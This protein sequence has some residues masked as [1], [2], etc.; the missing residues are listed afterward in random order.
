MARVRIAIPEPTSHDPEY[1]Q[2]S[3]PQYVA[4]IE[5]A[6]GEA[7]PIALDTPLDAI[8]KMA[9]GCDGILL[10]GS[11]AD[12]D[13]LRYRQDRVL[14]CA[15]KDGA[16][17]AADDLL[18]REAIAA[19]KPLLGICFGLQSL[20]VWR[21][22][23]LIQDLPQGVNHVDHSPGSHVLDAHR[24]EISCGTRLAQLFSP[25]EAVNSSHHQAVGE[26]GQDLKVSARSQED[27]V[28][29]ALEGTDPDTFLLGVQWHPERSYSKS[30]TSRAIFASFL[31]AA[32]RWR[33]GRPSASQE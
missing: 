31:E 13:P 8:S 7:V 6:G 21:G 9:K 5:A 12:I 2:R 28:V 20:N 1:N 25:E 24:V 27:Q 3:L 16:R 26:P 32:G 23:S 29:E 15:E 4:A 30:A 18:L 17:E 19:G 22:G 14:A 10:P 33:V 11:P